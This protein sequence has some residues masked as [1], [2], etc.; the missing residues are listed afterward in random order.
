MYTEVYRLKPTPPLI[1]CLYFSAA[2]GT[3]VDQQAVQ[4]ST[5]SSGASSTLTVAAEIHRSAYVE[6]DDEEYDDVVQVEEGK[7]GE[8]LEHVAAEGR[9]QPIH[10]MG[11]GGGVGF[12]RYTSMYM[13]TCTGVVTKKHQK[14]TN[15]SALLLVLNGELVVGETVVLNYL[16]NVVSGPN[17]IDSFDESRSRCDCPARASFY[18]F[19]GSTLRLID[20][21]ST[22]NRVKSTRTCI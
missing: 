10:L 2:T 21:S 16:E 8:D 22:A 20:I 18:L 3:P 13:C 15:L 11:V 12:N 17:C 7:D 19:A 1:Y 4:R 6:D 5:P 14:L 9:F